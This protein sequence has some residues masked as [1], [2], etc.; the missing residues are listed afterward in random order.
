MHSKWL[1]AIVAAS[2]T[3]SLLAATAGYAQSAAPAQAGAEQR[4]QLPAIDK[5]K[6]S[7]ALGYKLGNDIVQGEVDVDI[8]QVI[9]GVQ[10]AYGKKQAAFPEPDLIGQLMALDDKLRQRA[11]AEFRRVADE[12][13]A[14]SERFLAE[15]KTKKGIVVLP[16]GIQYR[17]IEEGNGARPTANSEVTVHYRGSVANG[18]EFDSSFARGQ[19]ERFKVN[20]VLRGWQE[21]LPLMRVG[22]VWQIFLPPDMAYGERA[23]RVI[24]P[25]QALVFEIKLLDVK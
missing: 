5:P 1:A 14:K 7:Y 18:L 6:L 15:N 17:V 16:N 2:C 9:K 12:N 3:L 11:E 25:N 21:V 23:P 8:N 10:D 19:P 24:G 13:K 22:D 4:P 20:D